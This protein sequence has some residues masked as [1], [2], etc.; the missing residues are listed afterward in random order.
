M[1]QALREQ[2]SELYRTLV[3][4]GTS[5]RLVATDLYSKNV[6]AEHEHD[7]IKQ[8]E[9]SSTAEAATDEILQRI[10]AHLSVFPTN[11]SKVLDVLGREEILEPIVTSMRAKILPPTQ[12]ASA[13]VSAQSL[14]STSSDR[15][16]VC[17]THGQQ[18]TWYIPVY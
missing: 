15:H 14:T 4:A 10:K 1:A 5:R 13:A 9:T 7:K 11:I 16:H 18:G 6:I 17:T 8:L 12:T 3:K 2:Y